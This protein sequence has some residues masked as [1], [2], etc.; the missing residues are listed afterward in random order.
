V[1]KRSGLPDGDEDLRQL[2]LEELNAEI[3]RVHDRWRLSTGALANAQ[4]RKSLFSRLAWLETHR[5]RE[6]GVPA[7]KRTQRAR[8]R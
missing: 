4:H 5:E 6:Y 2:S 8:Q 3:A 7:P 1:G